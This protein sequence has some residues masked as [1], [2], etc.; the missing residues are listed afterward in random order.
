MRS[1]AVRA[2]NALALPALLAMAGC[3]SVPVPSEAPPAAKA[4]PAAAS[5]VRPGPVLPPAGSGRGAYY[6]DDGPGENVP[7]DLDQVPDAQVRIEALLPRSNRPYVVVGKTYRPVTDNKPFIQRGI[8]SWYGK[9]FNGQRTASG[10]LYDMYKMT[11]AHPTLPIPSFAR[12]TNIGSGRQVIVRINDRGPF[13]AGRV[14]DVS[15]TAALK[16]GLLEK[17]SRQ[18]QV[19]RLLPSD[20]ERM[21]SGS[22]F[23]VQLGA[24]SKAVNAEAARLR[25][26]PHAV[27]LGALEVVQSGS[28][29]RLY[30]GPFDSRAAAA[31]AAREVPDGLG[32]KPVVIQR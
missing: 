18:L 10:E 25:A 19:E 22:G 30:G 26:E 15:Y 5:G 16:L 32:L 3:A 1:Q 31:L 6:K 7:P 9:K 13:H 2:A 20:I 21:L 24:F 14:I 17:G 12:V 11:A 8:G 29:F 23:F 27:N 28:L 4:P